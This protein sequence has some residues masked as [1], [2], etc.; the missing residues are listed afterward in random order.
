MAK[1]SKLIDENEMFA[2]LAKATGGEVLGD[3]S[4]VAYYIDTGNLAVNYICSGKFITGG[5][6]GGKITES[7][8][9]EA[10]GKSLWGYRLI[11]S[12]QKMGGIGVILDCERA[13]NPD[14]ARNIGQVDLGKTLVYCPPT[15]EQVERVVIRTVEAIRKQKGPEVPIFIVWD[16]IGVTMCEREWGDVQKAAKDEENSKEQPGERAKKAGALLRKL[17]PFLDEHRATMYVVNQI[18]S[19]I[20]VMYGDPNT[21]AGGGKALPFYA[22]LR[23]QL[24][25]QKKIEDKTLKIPLGVNLKVMNKKNRSFVPFLSTEGVQLYFDKGINPIGG[26]LSVLV[27]AKRVTGTHGNYQVE[28]P[29]AAGRELKFKSSKERNDVPA[30]VLLACPA[31]IDATSVEQVRDYLGAYA[32][33]IGLSYSDEVEEVGVDDDVSHLIN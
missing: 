23:L 22:S 12:V 21:T 18:R 25:A 28:E 3:L 32:E 17:N 27:G 1:K 33:A 4:R 11:S 16:S 15:F 7:F 9:P 2:D 26:L 24:A 8:G 20:G 14:F 31:V 29:W 5:I 10:S 19:K 13:V 6:P 30:D